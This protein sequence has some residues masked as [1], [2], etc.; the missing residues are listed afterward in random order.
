MFMGSLPR[1]MG[2]LPM[3][4]GVWTG[5]EIALTVLIFFPFLPLHITGIFGVKIYVY[6]CIYFVLNLLFVVTKGCFWKMLNTE[7]GLH[8]HL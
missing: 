7:F 2:R 8:T 6:N 3:F 1:N 4:L 5:F